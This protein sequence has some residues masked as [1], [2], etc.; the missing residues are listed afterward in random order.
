M[1]ETI[2]KRGYRLIAPTTAARPLIA[3]LP[4]DNLT[5]DSEQSYLADGVTD[6]LISSLGAHRVLRV[7]SRHSAMA[8]RER[9]KQLGQITRELG[10]DYLVEGSISS[11]V[12]GRAAVAVRLIDTGDG[13]CRWS[14]TDSVTLADLVS[15]QNEVALGI[16]GE[17]S[18]EPA[19]RLA[20]PPEGRA[21]AEAVDD[22]L[23]GRFHFYKFDPDEFPRAIACFE[24]AIAHSPGFAAAHAAIADV[25]GAYGYWGVRSATEI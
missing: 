23:R 19:F 7:L 13:T 14:Q 22:Y 15:W 18:Q 16:V 10:L 1:L 20:G 2:P 9:G 25:W 17:V 21:R 5:G 8:L 6:L 24:S 12:P 11:L 4:L 3:I